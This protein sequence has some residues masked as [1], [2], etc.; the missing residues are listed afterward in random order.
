MDAPSAAQGSHPE[1]SHSSSISSPALCC[2]SLLS[3]KGR[4]EAWAL[5]QK[6]QLL[7]FFLNCSAEEK[8]GL[9]EEAEDHRKGSP[10]SSTSLHCCAGP[11]ESRNLQ[12]DASCP[13]LVLVPEQSAWQ[14]PLQSLCFLSPKLPVPAGPLLRSLGL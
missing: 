11:T 7:C 14:C 10:H 12:G 6:E 5:H 13:L 4:A 2:C 1:Q 3:L 9:E 8:E